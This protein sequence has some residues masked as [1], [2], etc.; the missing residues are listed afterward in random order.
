MLPDLTYENGVADD[1][2]PGL[3]FVPVPNG[4]DYDA[5]VLSYCYKQARKASEICSH[6]G[7]SDS[8]YFRQK[9][10]LNL[11]HEGYL[12]SSKVGRASYYKTVREAVSEI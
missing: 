4:T 8:T 11:C 2:E 3:S 9:V 6:L 12:E 10:L 1:A 7:I 5:R